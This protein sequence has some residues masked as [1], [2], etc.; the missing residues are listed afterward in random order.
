MVKHSSELK[1]LVEELQS[2]NN[3]YQ[4]Q[5][6]EI[7]EKNDELLSLHGKLKKGSKEL[8]FQTAKAVESEKVKSQFLANMSHELRTPQ[9]SIL[10]LT[11]LILKDQSTSPK[12]KE[13][14]NVVLRNGKKLVNLS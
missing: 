8:E 10:G 12:T 14:L 6:L 2:L 9:N 11:E 4:K 13:R 1:K 7:S 3:A 5:N